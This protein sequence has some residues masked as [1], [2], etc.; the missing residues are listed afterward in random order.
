MRGN[1]A[2]SAQKRKALERVTK[3][4]RGI[5]VFLF[6]MSGIINVLA[7]T[8]SFYM[9]QI[10]DR[11]L[12]SGS[13]PTLV[14]LS[15]LAVGLYLF[16]G[17]FDVIRSQ[18]LVRVGA[19]LDKRVAPIAHQVAIDM[20][21]FGF[22]TA[23]ALER[24]RDVDTVRGFL[25]G[26]GPTALF[27]LP[28][29]PLYLIFVYLLHPLLGAITFAGAFVLALL[30]LATEILTRRLSSATHQAIITRNAIADS[31]ARNAD[32]LK[33]MG[34]AGRAVTRFDR[35]NADHLQLQT[36]TNDI[37]GTFGAVSRVLR[38][39]LQSSILG[40]GAYLTILGELSAGAIIAASVT[41]ARALAPVDLAIAN[42]KGVVAA[43]T[44]FGRIK[45]TV[46]ALADLDPPMELPAPRTL[47]MVEKVT[48]AAPDSG[49]VLLSDVEFKLEAGQALGVIGPS[50][51]GKTTL[52]RALTGI[53]PALRGSVRLDGAELSQW[54]DEDLGRHI[55]YLPQDVSLLDGT[56]EENIS[57]FDQSND[58]RAT[59]AAAQIAGVHEMIVRLP[60][61][62]RTKLGSQGSALSA[63]Q[64]QRI[65]L[66]RALY[67]DPFLVVMDEPNSNLDGEGEAALTEAIRAVRAR[68]GIAIV[69]AHRPSALMAVDLVAV[70]Q[71]GR[72]SA[73]GP[74]DEI[75]GAPRG[76][77]IAP[78]PAERVQP[79]VNTRVLA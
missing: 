27:D 77:A 16:Q 34:M 73:F 40:L 35:A 19:R 74:K 44:A 24:G 54:R 7:L 50:G 25:G 14:A 45:E 67:K 17:F 57:R 3:G 79:R 12:T 59:I 11:A 65:G 63:G 71:N 76:P 62:Y 18:V 29:M 68:G 20:P 23:E 47:L 21:R 52:V 49:R 6:V 28:W 8:G 13:I 33:A 55:G 15:V 2:P 75:I 60:E 48:V 39:I 53:W 31:N 70:I 64:R 9:L 4:L 26:Q 51:G 22:S 58:P 5:V 69:V 1:G 66:A 37:S 38:M 42:W 78:S 43:R 30:T 10:Y 46:T 41:S 36:R 72:M 32:I 56:V 61:G